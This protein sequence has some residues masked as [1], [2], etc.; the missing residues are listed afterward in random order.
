MFYAFAL[1]G[2]DDFQDCEDQFAANAIAS[3]M[4][5]VDAPG[6]PL[7]FFSGNTAAICLQNKIKSS[8]NGGVETSN[9]VLREYTISF[10]EG[11][12]GETRVVAGSL[13]ADSADGSTG[14]QGS[15]ISMPIALFGAAELQAITDSALAAGGTTQVT[16]SVIFRG[17]TTGGMDVDTPEWFFPVDIVSEQCF[18]D[19]PMG[20]TAAPCT[21]VGFEDVCVT[22]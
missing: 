17:R 3:R 12:A 21:V 19:D 22:P 11:G 2:G 9:I 6:G 10:S 5:V 13:S 20:T 14:L 8:R 4:V 18:C 1:A 7:T 16:A 15:I